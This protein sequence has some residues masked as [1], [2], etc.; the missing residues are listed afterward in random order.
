MKKAELESMLKKMEGFSIT[1]HNDYEDNGKTV[2]EKNRDLVETLESIMFRLDDENYKWPEESI[3]MYQWICDN[4][5]IALYNA[6]VVHCGFEASDGQ[7]A[8]YD[9]KFV[10]EN[11]ICE[12]F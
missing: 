7:S 1:I 4:I 2:E 5:I 3:E 8:D 9:V 10:Y 12:D 6:G 11:K